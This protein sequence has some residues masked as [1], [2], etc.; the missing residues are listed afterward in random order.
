MRSRVSRS[1]ARV[2]GGRVA[3]ESAPKSDSTGKSQTHQLEDL[4]ARQ[5]AIDLA[6]D[7]ALQDADDFVLDPALLDALEVELGLGVVCDANHDD[8]P[9]RAV[10]PAIATVVGLDP[11]AG[12]TRASRVGRRNEIRDVRG[13]I[14]G[15]MRSFSPSARSRVPGI[16]S[17]HYGFRQHIQCPSSNVRTDELMVTNQ[18]IARVLAGCVLFLIAT[19][20]LLYEAE[21]GVT[22]MASQEHSSVVSTW[23]NFDVQ[24]QCIRDAITRAVPHDAN[25]HIAQNQSGFYAGQ[26]VELSTPWARPVASRERANYSLAIVRG[27][28]C[29]GESLAVDPIR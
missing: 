22:L 4:A 26:L 24:Q 29:N 28:Q 25:V 17:G 12:L 27:T 2:E 10:G 19:L 21:S 14:F 9:Q 6:G 8:A 18:V 20:L 5:A 7:V 3:G 16:S 13:D 11:A 1:S 15:A 23:A